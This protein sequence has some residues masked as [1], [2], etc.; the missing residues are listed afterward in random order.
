MSQSI[1]MQQ[2]LSLAVHPS[3]LIGVFGPLFFSPSFK[4]WLF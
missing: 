3:S 2:P 4:L 1:Y